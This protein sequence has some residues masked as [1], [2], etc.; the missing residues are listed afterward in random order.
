MRRV[1]STAAGAPAVVTALYT[2]APY[3]RPP[4]GVAAVLREADRPDA[5]ARPVPVAK[6]VRAGKAVALARLAARAA[7]RDRPGVQQRVALTD[8]AEALQ[9]QLLAQ[10]P[11]YT[12]VPD[13][14]HAAAYLWDTANA[15][16]GERH[17][18]RTAWVRSHLGHLL[19]GQ[20]DT[21]I[22]A[23]QQ[24]ARAPTCTDAQRG[25]ALRTVGYYQR[26]APY[27]RY[28]AY[29]AQGW[30]IGT[31]V[32]EGACGHLVKDRMEQS[33]MR[34]TLAGAP[35]VLDLRAVRCNGD[36]DAYRRFHRRQQHQ[37][38][39]GDTAAI[40]GVAAVQLDQLA[41]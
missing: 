33:G 39:Y 28:D 2:I 7:Q 21:V 4:Q 20:T 30:P 31:S 14:I 41:A 5:P 34:W 3:R 38:L 26:N 22:A 25:G 32:V 6:A 16:L 17:A 11:G 8:G 29:L 37:R 1:A 35:A 24:A 15:L 10:F 18:G 19:A 23:L 27:M 13:I 12:L 36:W 40:P 9:Q